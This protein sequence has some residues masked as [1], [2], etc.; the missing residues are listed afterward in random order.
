MPKNQLVDIKPFLYNRTWAT[1]YQVAA[2]GSKHGLNSVLPRR[3]RSTRASQDQP[4]FLPSVK[5]SSQRR[6]SRA[7]AFVPRTR[8]KASPT[9]K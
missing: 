2:V 5:S 4:S 9:E 3:W 1:W 7:G 6:S 8:L